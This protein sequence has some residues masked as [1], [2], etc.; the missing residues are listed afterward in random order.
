MDKKL[1]VELDKYIKGR[2]DEKLK[3][4]LDRYLRGCAGLIVYGLAG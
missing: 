1:K 4:E 3:V 2:L